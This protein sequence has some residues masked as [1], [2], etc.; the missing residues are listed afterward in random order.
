[1][2]IR[3][4]RPDELRRRKV[5]ELGLDPNRFELTSIEAIAAAIR[6]AATFLCPCTELSMVHSIVN[7]LQG[8]VED[9]SSLTRSVKQTLNA[10]I[11]QG[12]LL[13]LEEFD[14]NSS[15]KNTLLFA[16]PAAFVPR[17]TGAQFLIGI[18]G[19]ELFALP[20]DLAASIE[21]AG[22]I[23]RLWPLANN[24]LHQKLEECG[25]LE[26]PFDYWQASP[27]FSDSSKLIST[28]DNLLDSA[29]PSGEIP[30]LCL[31]DPDRSVKYY[32]GRW[33]D[34]VKQSGRFVARRK[35]AYGAR[36]WSY[37]LLVDGE[38]QALVDLPLPGSRWHGRD[39]AWHLQM[40]IDEKRK[41]PQR[42]AIRNESRKKCLIAFFSP[43]PSWA[44]RRW[45]AIG[46][47][48]S[49]ERCLFA[50]RIP[51]DELPQEIE[52]IHRKLFL[53]QIIDE[54]K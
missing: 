51:R 12:D 41:T 45:N 28:Y 46:E 42:F 6:R 1:M 19:D 40:A 3:R 17:D 50:Y 8:L 32:R 27:K 31:L 38:P 13:E 4:L 18:S 35:Q 48:V 21:Y 20:E 47:R 36:L 5:I 26:I 43:I 2:D 15:D 30:G 25:L 33:V 34:P 24:N 29:G 11:S 22:H 10:M 9:L 37:V 49:S 16:A 54:G 7:P 39:E 52:F 23:R 44:E 53:D 14:A